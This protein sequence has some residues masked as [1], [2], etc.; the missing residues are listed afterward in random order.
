[1]LRP[2]AKLAHTISTRGQRT[3]IDFGFDLLR[4][5]QLAPPFRVFRLKP[6]L[7]SV[8]SLAPTE[9]AR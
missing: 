9:N 7:L 3:Y 5:I 4:H 8:T 6:Y 1:M 2:T